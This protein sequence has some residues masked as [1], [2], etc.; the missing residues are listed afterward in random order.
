MS[1]RTQIANWTV[2]RQVPWYQNQAS[3][4]GGERIQLVEIAQGDYDH[5][6]SDALV[7]DYKS[8]GEGESFALAV[9]AVKAA[10]AIRDAWLLARPHAKHKPMIGYG[11]THGGMFEI[12]PTEKTDE[13]LRAWA[14]EI[15]E[16]LPR[17]DQCGEPLPPSPFILFEYSDDFKFC[18]EYCA[19][20]YEEQNLMNDEE[21]EMSEPV[22]PAPVKLKPYRNWHKR[23]EVRNG[24][25]GQT[26]ALVREALQYHYSSTRLDELTRF[27]IYD[28]VDYKRLTIT[29][30]AE[31][32]GYVKAMFSFLKEFHCHWRVLLDG[33]HIPSNEVPKGRW[34]DVVPDAGI[35][36]W[37][38]APHM[39]FFPERDLKEKADAILAAINAQAA[40]AAGTLPDAVREGSNQD[41]VTVD[42]GPQ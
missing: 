30:R 16:K 20:N 25:Q 24:F 32:N 37:N 19:E 38:D 21:E 11:N 28:R 35:F 41:N 13:E 3:G 18:S 9:D 27:R 7:E 5:S 40:T 23:W 1:R 22:K 39:I 33:Q 12:E 14:A 17:C 31:V 26:I 8:L 2:T 34:S 36:V 15:D 6:G 10:I 29:E 4:E 42:G